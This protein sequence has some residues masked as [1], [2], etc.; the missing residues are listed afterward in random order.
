MRL[1][2]IAITALAGCETVFP[3]E[4]DS[5][6]RDPDD[7]LFHDED[8]DGFDDE[9]DNCPTVANADQGHELDADGVGDVCDPRPDVDGDRIA[10]FESFHG[11][12][13]EAHWQPNGGS[14]TWTV[15][16]DQLNYAKKFST[17]DFVVDQADDDAMLFPAEFTVVY[18]ITLD[19]VPGANQFGR[20]GVFAAGDG[21]NRGL[22]CG[23]T[24]QANGE[25]VALK[26]DYDPPLNF[27]Q[28]PAVVLAPGARFEIEL[29][30]TGDETTC[31]T[32]DTNDKSLIARYTLQG[33]LPQGR[34]QMLADFITLHVDYIV[35]YAR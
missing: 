1:G 23:M 8:G 32:I 17:D 20:F 4:F 15:A 28:G 24:H 3:L 26:N 10:K 2:L 16:D 29:A 31:T 11:P 9:C 7:P 27:T 33:P 30:V 35:V 18:T 14:G 12:L 22:S 21:N 13:A 34:L 5:P 25:F 6:C 19:D